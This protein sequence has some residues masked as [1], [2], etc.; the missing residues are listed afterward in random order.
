MIHLKNANYLPPMYVIF[1]LFFKRWIALRMTPNRKMRNPMQW[2]DLDFKNIPRSYLFKP[3]ATSLA[4]W[5][6]S[7]MIKVEQFIVCRVNCQECLRCRDRVK[8]GQSLTSSHYHSAPH[9]AGALPGG[10]HR[11][12][13]IRRPRGLTWRDHYRHAIAIKRSNHLFPSITIPT[14][15]GWWLLLGS[16]CLNQSWD[17]HTINSEANRAVKVLAL[18]RCRWLGSIQMVEAA[19]VWPRCAIGGSTCNL[20]SGRQTKQN[21]HRLCPS[22]VQMV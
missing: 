18:A 5:E 11:C 7:L 13:P 8:W 10:W 3:L 22:L 14:D 21:R 15:N 17:C 2:M 19:P 16:D 20:R 12:A 4:I 9:W 1:K 6:A